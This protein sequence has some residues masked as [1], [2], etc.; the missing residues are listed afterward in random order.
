MYFQE[1]AIKLVYFALF[2]WL[3]NLNILCLKLLLPLNIL[4]HCY[5]MKGCFRLLITENNVMLLPM[6]SASH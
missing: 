5:Y 4:K 6:I 2:T 3:G 1:N